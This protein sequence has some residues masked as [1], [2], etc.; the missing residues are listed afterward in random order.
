M[1]RSDANMARKYD[2]NKLA[3]LGYVPVDTVS[4]AICEFGESIK[5]RRDNVDG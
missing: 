3:A 5:M 1:R 2:S 4:N